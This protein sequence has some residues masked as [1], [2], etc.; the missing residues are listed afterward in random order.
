MSS[1]SFS[2]PMKPPMRISSSLVLVA[3]CAL[4]AAAQ[5]PA[6]AASSPTDA[7]ARWVALTAPT[8]AEELATTA[9]LRVLPGWSRDANGNL[10]RRVGHG[11]PRRVVACALDVSGY[12][13]S[14]ITDDG[15]LRLHRTGTAPASP[16]ADQFMEAHKVRIYTAH[17]MRP[18]VVA[19]ANGHFARQHRA[20]TTVVTADQLW[21]DVGASS[22]A[23]T[24][25][26]SGFPSWIRSSPT[27][28][29]G[30]TTAS[31]RA[32][33]PRRARD[34]RPSPPPRKQPFRMARRSL[35]SPR[36][37]R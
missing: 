20:D 37:T 28:L 7:I 32:P 25:T 12:V 14:E 1:A 33:A 15:Y 3:A 22:R 17:A 31:S 35:S 29:C 26:A 27:A 13:V 2:R 18:G 8:G 21:V 23:S 9:L 6:D 4:R 5:A 11:T 16:L 34:A 10:V 19:I 24:S 30:A 36:S